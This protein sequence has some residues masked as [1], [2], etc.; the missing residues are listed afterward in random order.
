MADLIPADPG[1]STEGERSIAKKMIEAQQREIKEFDRRLAK[2][3]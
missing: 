2:H 3:K 1:A